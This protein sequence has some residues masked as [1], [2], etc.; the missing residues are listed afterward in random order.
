SGGRSDAPGPGRAPAGGRADPVPPGRTPYALDPRGVPT[1]TA[2]TLGWQA[3]DALIT[4]YLQDH[5][6]WPKR[7]VVDCW[8]TP[9]MR[10]G[11]DELAQAMALLGVRPLWENGSGRVTGFEVMPASVLG[12]PRVDVTLRISGLFRDVF[13]QQIALFDQAVRAVMA[14][15]EPADVNPVAS[16]L[17]TDRAELEAGGTPAAEA[18]RWASARVF[19]AAPG[20]Y[21]TALPGLIARGDWA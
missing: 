18:G 8:G 9:A 7:L 3:A 15:D 5:G 13:P 11:G 20:A 6:D 4:R 2:W 16:A 17:R 21:G 19:G 10:T 12:R 14:E 1:P